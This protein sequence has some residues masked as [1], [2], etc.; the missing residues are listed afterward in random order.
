[1][2]T[3]P[4]STYTQ[5]SST[6]Q[7]TVAPS[8]EFGRALLLTTD[9]NVYGG[10]VQVFA[11]LTALTAALGSTSPAYIAAQRYFAQGPPRPKPLVVGR[12]AE[13]GYGGVVVGGAPD[14][15]EDIQAVTSGTLM[16]DSQTLSSVDFSGDTSFAAV[17]A[18]LQTL[19]RATAEPKQDDATVEYERGRFIVRYSLDSNS[20]PQDPSGVFAGASAGVLGLDE[21]SGA[22]RHEGRAGGN[23]CRC[24]G[25][26]SHGGFLLEPP[27][28]RHGNH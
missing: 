13:T 26:R 7:P 27:Y 18:S 22:V 8:T 17:A 23:R 21:D 20:E 14:A 6:L 19:L 15:L 2:T 5:V 11:T 16:F 4:I 24:P 3:L 1:M 28:C 25:R 10:S 12:W 9:P